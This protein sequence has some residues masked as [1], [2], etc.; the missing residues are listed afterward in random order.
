MQ[1][2]FVVFEEVVFS[3]AQGEILHRVSFELRTGEIVGLLGPNGAGKSTTIKIMAGLLT[4]G[5]GKVTVAGLSL[6]QAANEVKQRIGYVPEAA[7]LFD[8]LTGQEFLELCGRLHDV[9][10]DVLQRRIAGMLETFDL[11]SDRSSRLDAYSKGMRQ[12][13]LIAS[14]LLHNP[15]LLLLDEPLSGL[16]VNA[17]ILIKDLLSSLAAEGKTILYSSHVLDVVERVCDRILVIH[18]GNLIA[19]GTPEELMAAS[20][21]S[22][23]EDAFRHLTGAAGADTGVRKIIDT[24]RP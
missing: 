19:T 5:G 15:D 23:L 9:P 22:T 3:Y 7:V 18:K 1:D 17:A 6:P 2:R 20:G 12:K 4:P 11:S 10:E 14:A 8:S 21:Q 13:I 16:D 24:L